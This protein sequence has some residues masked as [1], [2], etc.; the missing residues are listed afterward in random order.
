MN[1][2][3]TYKG[4]ARILKHEVNGI[5]LDIQ[6]SSPAY[7]ALMERRVAAGNVSRPRPGEFSAPQVISGP[8]KVD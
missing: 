7:F 4:R 8:H 1:G 3:K 6:C 5:R 2:L